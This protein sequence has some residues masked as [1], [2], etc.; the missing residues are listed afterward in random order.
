M[1]PPRPTVSL[2]RSREHRAMFLSFYPDA[3]IIV[4][5]PIGLFLTHIS[6]SF[7]VPW[8]LFFFFSHDKSHRKVHIILVSCIVYIFFCIVCPRSVPVTT[9]RLGMDV[10]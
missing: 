7:V 6:S 8:C 2:A 3:L 10:A 4:C 5:Y 9:S 1:M